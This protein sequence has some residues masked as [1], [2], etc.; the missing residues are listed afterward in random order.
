[1]GFSD[2]RQLQG[3]N[4]GAAHRLGQDEESHH[5]TLETPDWHTN[6]SQLPG[7]PALLRLQPS[8]SRRGRHLNAH[9]WIILPASA[10]L[11]PLEHLT[12]SEMV[13]WCSVA[14]TCAYTN[15]TRLFLMNTWSAAHK[16]SHCYV[17]LYCYYGTFMCNNML[18]F[19]YLNVVK[20]PQK[21]IFKEILLFI[22]A[23]NW[24]VWNLLY[25]FA[26][27]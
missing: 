24:L 1:M 20:M 10:D 12:Q 25:L 5:Q 7:H 3:C 2:W 6:L 22:L 18:H 17:F 13:H 19:F 15:I 26:Y 11:R 14:T 4:T 23:N 8:H 21:P 16:H 9:L 27:S